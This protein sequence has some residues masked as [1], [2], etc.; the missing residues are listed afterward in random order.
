VATQPARHLSCRLKAI[1]FDCLKYVFGN[2]SLVMSNLTG[3]DS[4]LK[5][6]F[7]IKSL[8]KDGVILDLC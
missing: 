3:I 5:A 2:M 8:G 7:R 6:D 4:R 1:F